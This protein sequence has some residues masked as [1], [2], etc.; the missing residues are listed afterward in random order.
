MRLVRVPF[1]YLP[2]NHVRA[3]Y[4]SSYRLIKIIHDVHHN[5]PNA[6]WHHDQVK[7]FMYYPSFVRWVF[8]KSKFEF[9]KRGFR[10]KIILD[11]ALRSLRSYPLSHFIP[12]TEQELAEDIV[13][14]LYKWRTRYSP[15]GQ[16][17][18]QSYSQL[19]E[20]YHGYSAEQAAIE[21]V[22]QVPGRHRD[23][24]RGWYYTQ[25]EE[26]TEEN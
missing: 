11:D 22:D 13:W 9:S 24:D 8:D 23:A 21:R 1:I 14:L 25:S 4:L 7:A 12:P 2:D 18:P 26:A 15:G 16:K 6:D 20:K 10:C 3:L 19:S 17:L 5:I